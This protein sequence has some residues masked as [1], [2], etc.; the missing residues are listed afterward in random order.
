MMAERTIKSA[1]GGSD[2]IELRS[3]SLNNGTIS[4]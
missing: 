1:V 2:R 4:S 3:V